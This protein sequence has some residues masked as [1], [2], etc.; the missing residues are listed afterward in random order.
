M[1]T[2]ATNSVLQVQMGCTPLLYSRC[3]TILLA[4]DGCSLIL[5]HFAASGL[6]DRKYSTK[7]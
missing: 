7:K 5:L 3:F 4:A 1:G 2:K 6:W